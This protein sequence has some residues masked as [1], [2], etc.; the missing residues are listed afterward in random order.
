MLGLRPR[1]PASKENEVMNAL[2][3]VWACQTPNSFGGRGGAAKLYT[4]YPHD[5][6][7]VPALD[8]ACAASYNLLSM[9]I[10]HVV[11]LYHPVATGS[12][13]YF[14]EIGA[15]LVAEGHQ[16]TVLTSDAYDLE[17]FWMAGKRRAEPREEMYGGVRIVRL[18]V[19]RIPG[20]PIVYPLLRRAMVETSRVPGSELLL[21][22]M[23]TVTPQ[24]P[25]L[26][27][28]LRSLGP[29]DLLHTTNIT[30]DFAIMPAQAFAK[31][32]G[33]PFLVTPLM[34]LGEPGDTSL[35]RY[36]S[37]RHQ[38]AVLR[39]SDR[40]LTM[41]EIERAYLA[42]RGIAHERLRRVGVGVTPAEL[43]GGDAARFRAEHA[44]TGPI[45]LAIGAMARDKG[46][47]H[48]V[49]AMQRLWADG[50]DATLVLIGAPLEHFS[51]FYERLPAEAKAR[52]RLLAYATDQTKR[53]ALAA[54][55]LLT[56]PSR[57]DSFGIV[58]LE[59]WVYGLPVVGAR[60]GGVPDVID[61]EQDGL[62]V[63]FG[64]VAALA[65]AF[66]RLLDNPAE[67]RRMGETG[68]AKVV[69]EFTWDQVYQRVR[70]V[71]AEAVAPQPHPYSKGQRH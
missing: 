23:A 9:N 68:R 24:L 50:S 46:T 60:A 59:G 40:V 20:P 54:A 57:T 63:P 52:I 14:A 3:R 62:L 64:D 1:S 4:Y 53:D 15:R 30:L 21:R 49:E 51:A 33:V 66:R 34:H 11:Q 25:D 22:H 45:V 38:L 69:R 47:M 29:I 10:V 31:K 6:P 32:Q 58:F 71:Y 37:M 67:A 36:Y 28:T 5:A 44:I 35:A 19:R 8:R 55:A 16:V 17:H 65:T 18:P 13:R 42:S 43:A 70:A 12:A 27:P 2:Q 61:D 41:T 48:V 7:A 56:L 39:A 26:L